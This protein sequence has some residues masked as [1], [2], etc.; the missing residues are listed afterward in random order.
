[1]RGGNMIRDI[2]EIM[3]IIGI[4]GFSVIITL[5]GS[6]LFSGGKEFIIPFFP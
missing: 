4:I 2:I 5:V 3:E 6:F 1:M